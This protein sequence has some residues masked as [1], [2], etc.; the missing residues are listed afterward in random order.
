MRQVHQFHGVVAY[1][2]AVGNDILNLQ[3]MLHDLGY[4]S[5]VFASYPQRG[6]ESRTFHWHK[7]RKYS[8]PDNV[9]L[10]HFSIGYPPEVLHWLQTLP[11]RKV[12]IYHNITPASYYTGISDVFFEET[13]AG[14]RQLAQLLPVTAAGWGD[15]DFNRQELVAIG[16]RQTAVLPIVF[17]AALYQLVPDRTTRN[18][19][20]HD[21][22]LN[23]LFIGRVVPNKKFEDVILAFYHLKKFIEP[24]AR[25]YLVGSSDQ[26]EKY[27]AYLQALVARLALTD[28]HF[29]GH[30]SR[31]ELIAYYR[32]ADVYLC[33]SEH[34]GFGVP[35]IESMYFDVPV[36][37]YAAAAVPE[38][39]GGA[40]VL[41][42]RKDHAAIA[43]L[44][45]LVVRDELLRA[46]LVA[47]QR[48]R[49]PQFTPAALQP[50]LQTCLESL[51]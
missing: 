34:E 5:E 39:M 4:A 50:T 47:Q 14:R 30:V 20:N 6:F 15:S 26:M 46:R 2:D 27:A 40:G 10:C 31:E 38:T 35:L 42:T 51:R 17:E 25:L 41:V 48:Q 22:A 21:R 29:I 13:Y 3:K 9:L 28:V 43:E 49:W 7:H 11:D 33:L 44:I 8:S 37:A 18:R 19:L 1:G 24:C 45:N 16:W 36:I 32:A 12:L 23:V